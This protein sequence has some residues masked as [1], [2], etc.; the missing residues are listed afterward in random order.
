MS[1]PSLAHNHSTPRAPRSGKR[2]QASHAITGATFADYPSPYEALKRELH[3]GAASPGPEPITPGKR[4][5]L[6]DMSMTPESSPFIAPNTQLRG[7]AAPVN[8]DPLFHRVLD[9]TYRIAATPHTGRKQKP[10]VGFTPGTA[11][12]AAPSRWTDDSS[13]PSSPAPQLRADIFSS[14]MKAPRTPGVSVQRTPARGQGNSVKPQYTQTTQR[15]MW[16]SESDDE[17]DGLD[18][19][20]PKTMQF[21]VPQSRLLQTPGM[22][23]LAFNDMPAS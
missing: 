1:S 6:P 18:F 22:L 13:P 5:A 3:G 7:S 14:P 15:G 21:H 11:T 4:Q 9:K 23:C 16:D 19:S 20:P 17:D 2:S 8:D 10:S 12:H